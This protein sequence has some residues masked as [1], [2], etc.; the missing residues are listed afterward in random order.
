MKLS[1]K[2]LFS[3][4]WA[5]L[6]SGCTAMYVQRSYD[7]EVAV[8]NGEV[9]VEQPVIIIVEEPVFYIPQPAINEQPI[10]VTPKT[11]LRTNDEN[12]NS[13]KIERKSDN[14][15]NNSRNNSGQRNTKSRGK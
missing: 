10:Q 4:F 5:V 14:S 15:E 9:I 3:G 8:E 1:G 7:E 13:Q 11:K 2:I 6:V 12:N